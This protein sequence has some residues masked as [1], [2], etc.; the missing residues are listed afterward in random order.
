MIQ[1]H[2]GVLDDSTWR[3]KRDDQ[4]DDNVQK[5]K[6]MFCKYGDRFRI[7]KGNSHFKLFPCDERFYL[8]DSLNYLSLK[9][10]YSLDT[11]HAGAE[12]SENVQLLKPYRDMFFGFLWLSQLQRLWLRIHV[13]QTLYIHFACPI[14][15]RI[16]ASGHS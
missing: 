3:A 8:M 5:L 12:L 14:G 9:G 4:S 10:V 1:I 7:Q 16:Y 15:G 6:R 13:G 2:Y 11:R